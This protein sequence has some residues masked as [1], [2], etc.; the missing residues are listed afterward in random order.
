MALTVFTA[1]IIYLTHVSR[2]DIERYEISNAAPIIVI[3]SGPFLTEIYF[4]DRAI[5]LLAVFVPMLIISLR[6]GIGMGDVKLMSAFGFVLGAIPAYFILL[7]ALSAALIA[8]K[9]IKT[10]SDEI[11]L[12]PYICTSAGVIYIAMEVILNA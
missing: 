2:V 8:G 5:G 6:L 10:Q 1:L 4:K 11:P 7:S 12:A 3:M 9:I